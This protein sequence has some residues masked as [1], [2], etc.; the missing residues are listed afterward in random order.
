ME[1]NRCN[2]QQKINEDSAGLNSR[3]TAMPLLLEYLSFIHLIFIGFIGSAL[4]LFFLSNLRGIVGG[5]FG[6]ETLKFHIGK[7]KFSL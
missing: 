6:Y 2:R 4:A 1:F 3:S 7:I 5:G